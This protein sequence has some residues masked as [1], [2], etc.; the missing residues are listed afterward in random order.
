[1]LAAG[2]ARQWHPHFA[3]SRA[4]LLAGPRAAHPLGHAAQG[5]VKR[6]QL[7]R[8]SGE[9]AVPVAAAEAAAVAAAPAAAATAAM[10]QPPRLLCSSFLRDSMPADQQLAV[11]LLNWT[12]PSI[13]AEL[14]QRGEPERASPT[15]NASDLARSVPVAPPAGCPA[16]SSAPRLTPARP[17][18]RN[19]APPLA[20]ATLRVC[21]DGGAN[22]LYDEL[23]TM[24]PGGRPAEEVRAA[25]LP[26]VICGD[27]D[28]VRPD[29]LAYYSERGVVVDDQSGANRAAAWPL[30]LRL[31]WLPLLLCTLRPPG[32]RGGCVLPARSGQRS[33]SAPLPCCA[34]LVPSCSRPNDD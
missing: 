28:S 8:D 30:L 26:S 19:H 13:T 7:A 11:V 23:H 15:L 9:V 34:C 6:A 5:R 10:G 3:G 27:L 1:M 25:H 24:L 31:L 21:A 29:V 17:P 2:A 20:A 33:R 14:W 22:R 16:G 32:E 12:L 18:P 4:R